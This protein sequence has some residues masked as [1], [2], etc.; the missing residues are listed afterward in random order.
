VSGDRPVL[1]VISGNPTAE[2]IAAI[3]AVV[4]GAI[5]GSAASRQV[6]G[7]QSGG[8]QGISGGR[9]GTWDRWQDRDGLMPQHWAPGS[10]A[11]RTSMLPR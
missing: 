8:G 5:A 6:V 7:T 4:T 9:T 11:W 3:L 1:R 2:E 10:G